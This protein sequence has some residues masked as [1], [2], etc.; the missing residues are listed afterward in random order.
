MKGNKSKCDLYVK[1]N[2]NRVD[3]IVAAGGGAV[4]VAAFALRV[5]SWSMQRPRSRNLLILD[6]PFVR[7]K[8]EKAN[9]RSL[10]L[11]ETISQRLKLQMLVVADERI[12]M[13]DLLEN[14]DGVFPVTPHKGVSKVEEEK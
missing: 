13:D 9:L 5:A 12:S 7:L 10:K 4:D 1:R 3:P 11:L 8:G 14:T 6:E 2:G